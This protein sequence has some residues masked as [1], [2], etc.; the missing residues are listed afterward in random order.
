MQQTIPMKP[1]FY[2]CFCIL[3][4]LTSL[5]QDKYFTVTGRIVD[6]K[7]QQPMPN[8]SVFARTPLSEP[9]LMQRGKFFLRL[10]PGG[11]DLVVSYTGYETKLQ[12]ISNGNKENDSLVIVLKEE[13]KAMAEVVVAGS[14]EVAD[15]WTKYGQFFMDNFIGTTPSAAQCTIDNKDVV[16][17]YFY[18]KEIN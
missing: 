3:I 12:R 9:Y 15:G 18:K 2:T 8:A 16:K 13:D 11:Y 6:E 5:S 17:F 10:S 1:F 7:T 14:A 4:S